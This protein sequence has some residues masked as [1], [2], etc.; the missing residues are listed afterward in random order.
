MRAR[1]YRF[2]MAPPVHLSS[3]RFSSPTDARGPVALGRFGA[4]LLVA[5]AGAIHL[6]LWFDYFHRVHVVGPL[7]LINAAAGI[8]VGT[9]LLARPG[10]LVLLA[11]AGYAL[12]TLAAFLVSTR[13]GLFGYHE[14]FW[15]SWQEAT[16]A[17]ELAA[18]VL[19]A[20]LLAAAPRRLPW[21]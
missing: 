13:W 21:P 7:F 12:G 11:L 19:V 8:L 1:A 4:A 15:G 6:Y 10:V 2:V 3:R 14:R 17:V 20:A 9:M 18:A 16:G 5:A